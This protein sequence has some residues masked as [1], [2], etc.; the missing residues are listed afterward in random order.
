MIV[1]RKVD[2]A[3]LPARSAQRGRTGGYH[4]TQ[5]PPTRIARMADRILQMS[6][7]GRT[8]VVRE[9][10]RRAT[11]TTIGTVL[12]DKVGHV[13][14]PDAALLLLRTLPLRTLLARA[15]APAPAG[16]APW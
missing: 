3:M 15:L 2:W 6:T 1:R 16:S 4:G 14:G 11:R 9:E 5:A 13:R 10:F 12:E 7:T 8:R